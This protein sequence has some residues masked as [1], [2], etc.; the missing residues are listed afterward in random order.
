MNSTKIREL[1]NR[2]SLKYEDLYKQLDLK[3]ATFYNYMSGRTQPPPDVLSR[4]AKILDAS[5]E[6]LIN[7]THQPV[8]GS[9]TKTE[10]MEKTKEQRYYELLEENYILRKRVEELEHRETKKVPDHRAG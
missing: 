2:K 3:R 9:S 5:I 1:A 10:V 6:E 8:I 4:F 7:E